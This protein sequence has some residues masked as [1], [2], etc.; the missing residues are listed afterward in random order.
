MIGRARVALRIARRDARRARGRSALVVAMIALPVLGV[1]AADVLY[2]TFQLSPDQKA[3]RSMGTADAV[4]QDTGLTRVRQYSGPGGGVDSGDGTGARTRPAASP[5]SV[6]PSGSRVLVNQDGPRGTLTA[7]DTTSTVALRALAYTDPVA[8]GIYVPRSGRAPRTAGELTLTTALADRLHVTLG[9]SV[10]LRLVDPDATSPSSRTLTV[11]GLVD[12]ASS[13]SSR[14]ALVAPAS[15]GKP[16]AG[17]PP[18][19]MLVRSPRPLSWADVERANAAGYVLQ[20]RGDVPGQPRRVDAPGATV[21]TSTLTAVSLVV[22]MAL[23]E[24]VLLAGPAFAV[25]AK[26]QSRELALLSASGA[27]REDVRGVVLGGGAVLGAVGGVVGV[28]VGVGLGRLAVPELTRRTDTFPGPFEVRPLEL[29]AI[30]AVGLITAVLAA[31]LP[32]RSAA[33]QDV[34][35]ALTGRRGQL[36]DLKRVP[37]LGAAL[38][39]L[40]AVIALEGARR[41]SVN[42]ILAG[43]ALAELGLVAT[44]PFLVGLVGRLGPWLPLS[45]RLALRD[46]A[47]N[48]S[49]TAP[50]VSAVL[51]AVA[52]SVAVG[53]YLSSLDSYHRDSY[54]PSAPIGMSVVPAHDLT[55]GM[56]PVQRALESTMPEA[57][58][59]QVGTLTSKVG[60]GP[61][62]F[63]DVSALRCTQTTVGCAPQQARPR[64]HHVGSPVGGT[65]VGDTATLA[66]LTGRPAG[67][68]ADLLARGGAVVPQE[69][70]RK[71]GT[72]ELLLP[73]LGDAL[74]GDLKNVPRLVLPARALPV[75]GPQLVLLG[76]SAAARTGSGTGVAA[77]VASAAHLPSAAE[78]DR[79]RHELAKLDL[80]GA[81]R[82]E[83]GYQG[84]SALGLLA[85]VLGSAVI[86]L[87]ASGIA[88]GLAAADGRADLA[89][90]AA[91]GASP[92]RRRSLAAFQSAVTAGLGTILG[93]AA[94]LV[95]AAGMVR[96]LNAE[97]L[98]QR[99]TVTNPYPLVLPW[100]NLVVTVVVVPLVAALAAALLTRSRLPLVRR[101]A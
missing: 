27:D 95:P 55:G 11:V 2:R 16:V 74:D 41:R 37:L 18:A 90:L 66:V 100:R 72:V 29:C 49:R 56:L 47:R 36:R 44:T 28:V 7:G 4:L 20:P 46:A 14:T 33:R 73:R 92:G 17:N 43:S 87:G 83:R 54:Q 77:V 65:L 6:L 40:G 31:M 19:P 50:A 84:G 39:V 23:L 35:A 22:G 1:G 38:A 8:R 99:F 88:T 81:L 52:G 26:R 71:D 75:D 68:Y 3:A 96:A 70:L 85:L 89:T 79:A 32:A 30:A 61:V 25:G 24:V 12:A 58:V 93:T 76:D 59:V 91:V 62:Q 63:S 67:A 101:L 15:L 53:T 42:T 82:V 57:T 78:E 21:T 13:R 69:L 9:D 64:L 86:V 10:R 60:K 5:T 80:D 97:A 34:V 48:R 98:Q 51:A 94:G 45:P